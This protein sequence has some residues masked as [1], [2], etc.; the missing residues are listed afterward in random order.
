MKKTKLVSLIA[1]TLCALMLLSS[2]SGASLSVKDVILKDAEYVRNA[3]P[4]YTKAEL[5]SGL[6]D[7]T[8]KNYSADLVYLTATAEV[9]TETFEKHIV[10]N[11]TLA[12]VVYTVTETKTTDISISLDYLYNGNDKIS[13]F[14]VKE[15]SWKL[16]NEIKVGNDSYKTT[17]YDGKGAV[18]A[19]ANANASVYEA[20]DLIYIDGKCYRYAEGAFAY[21]FDYSPLAYFPDI[22]DMSDKYYYDLDDDYIA[23]YDKELKLVSKYN[24]E[25]AYDSCDYGLLSNGNVFMQFFIDEM[26]DAEDYTYIAEKD[27]VLKKYTVKTLVIN[28]KSGSAKEI[29]CDYIVSDIDDFGEDYFEEMGLNYKKL[30]N[31]TSVQKIEDKRLVDIYY[32]ATINDNGSVVLF[33]KFEGDY[34][35]YVYM[36]ANDRYVVSCNNSDYLIDAKGKI[37]G[38]ISNASIY[39]GYMTCDGKAYDFDLNMLFDYKS[40]GY[41]KYD[42]NIYDI[43]FLT[44]SDNDIY[45]YTGAAAP[46]KIA[47]KDADQTYYG[48]VDGIIIIKTEGEKDKYTFY[49]LSGTAVLTIE[50]N[51]YIGY[52]A[53][54]DFYQISYGDAYIIRTKNADGDYVYYRVS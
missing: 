37:I 44:N 6:T 32:T 14:T 52:S 38:D 39:E 35:N 51:N 48:A 4:I 5:V 41:T 46:I 49:N 28:A 30:P 40:A 36:V 15:T 26:D 18:I 1:L 24:V 7:A 11:T 3:D 33:D 47:S 8:Y 21:A 23:V 12:S 22:Y 20:C 17:V 42:A 53:Y 54:S 27:G 34:V 45:I 29:K 43:L 19:S 13:F 10:Y 25:F 50:E 2:C 9:G 16:E 31:I